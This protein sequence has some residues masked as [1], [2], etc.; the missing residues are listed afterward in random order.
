MFQL[1]KNRGFGEYISDTF[2]FIKLYGKNY[3]KNYL[4]FAFFPLLLLMVC[5]AL[6]G[7][8]YYRVLTTTIGFTENETFDNAFITENAVILVIGVIVLVVISLYLSL[9]NYSYPVYYLHL[10]GKNNNEKPELRSI[11]SLFKN[12][13]G[14]LLLFGLLSFIIFSIIGLISFAIATIL[15]FII[16]GIFLFILIIPFFIAWYSL[17]LYF[18]IDKN[19][20]FF[21]AFKHALYTITN[22][23]WSIVGASLCMLIII[24]VISSIVTIIPYMITMLGIIFGLQQNGGMES[25]NGAGVSL[26]LVIMVVV[27]CF[28]I[29]VSMLLGHLLLIQTGLVY[30]SEREKL[31]YNTMR[32]SIDEIGK[33]E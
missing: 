31:E 21:D 19:Q 25:I 17:T 15:T 18:Y 8:F 11:K 20:S 14:K 24:Q 26:F 23:F 6:L 30:Y 13:L 10:L 12:D 16:I 2:H 28:S 4:K 9:L 22:N 29:I 5:M 1:F 27:Y 33:Y 3:F 7:T 32:K